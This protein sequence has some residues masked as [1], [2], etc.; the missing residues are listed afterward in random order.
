VRLPFLSVLV[1]FVCFSSAA[2]ADT[3]HVHQNGPAFAPTTVM[4]QVGDTVVWHYHSGYH[5]VTESVT[6]APSD[7]RAF[8]G[9]INWS[10]TTFS[11][12][13]DAALIAAHP[14]VNNRYG[15]YCIPHLNQ[16]MIGTVVVDV[17]VALPFCYG[18]GADGTD[19]PCLNNSVAGSGEGC[20]NSQGH[21]ATLVA[22]GST[23]FAADD[24]VLHIDQARPDQPAMILQGESAISIPFKDGKLC[25]GNPTE[26]MEVVFLDVNGAGSS[27]QSIITNGAVPGPGS[28]RYYQ[29]WYR[30]PQLDICGTRSNLTNALTVDWI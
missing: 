23:T 20:L 22:S 26:R 18:D 28:T 21:G 11:V 6:A 8:D 10:N 25:M 27:A 2:L 13:F 15:Y 29:V 3:I 17:P 7:G 12:T 16:G 1:A 24:L 4:V 19:C 9:I 5:T 14:R 30:D